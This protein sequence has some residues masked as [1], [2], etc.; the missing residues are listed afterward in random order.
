MEPKLK[1]QYSENL[2]GA[3]R[4]QPH[5]YMSVKLQNFY[6]EITKFAEFRL[7]EFVRIVCSLSRAMQD[8][9]RQ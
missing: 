7:G 1:V 2:H 6:E 4:L 3:L 5:I 8:P 9:Q